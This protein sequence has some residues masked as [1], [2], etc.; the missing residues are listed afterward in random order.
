MKEA[1]KKDGRRYISITEEERKTL[2]E[3][4]VVYHI[5]KD[6]LGIAPP[7]CKH[8]FV[9]SEGSPRNIKGCKKCIY[10]EYSYEL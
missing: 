6:T 1:Y 9:I 8:E 3:G 7:D 10:W 2:P 5:D 4:T